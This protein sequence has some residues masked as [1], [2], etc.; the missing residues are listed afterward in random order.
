MGLKSGKIAT[1]LHEKP[2]D[3]HQYLHFSLG[4]PNHA[5]CFV[6]F[7]Q[8]LCMSRLGYNES[9]FEWNKKKMR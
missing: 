1:D 7:S 3:R 8:T 4:H 6:I 9:D 5:K 2:T